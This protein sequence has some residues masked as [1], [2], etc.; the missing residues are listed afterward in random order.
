MHPGAHE[1]AHNS[2]RPLFQL[3]VD[4]ELMNNWALRFDEMRVVYSNSSNNDNDIDF[5]S[6]QRFGLLEERFCYG[7]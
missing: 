5:A 6:G 4:I 1:G 2:F 7:S 3:D